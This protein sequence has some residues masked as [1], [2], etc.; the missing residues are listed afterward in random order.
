MR[1]SGAAIWF[2]VGFLLTIL[3]GV[4]QNV[5][6]L[7]A[8]SSNFHIYLAILFFLMLST[9]A[10]I[11]LDVRR[12]Y[13]KRGFDAE[14]LFLS[15][16]SSFIARHGIQPPPPPSLPIVRLLVI[17]IAI[18][19]FFPILAIYWI[20]NP[21]NMKQV[22]QVASFVI[23]IISATLFHLYNDTAL[24]S[25]ADRVGF[26]SGICLGPPTALDFLL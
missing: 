4:V 20:F 16:T 22:I 21:G 3:L 8:K 26:Y 15:D 18:I 24:K 9:T 12:S 13:R 11:L 19:W 5:A 10:S 23:A 6:V 25:T 7:I 1:Y 14:D 17:A 2:G